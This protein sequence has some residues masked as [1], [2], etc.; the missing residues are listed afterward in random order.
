MNGGNGDPD[1]DGSTNLDEQNSGT[2]P[3][4]NQDFPV[5]LISVS[6][7]G[8]GSTI[9]PASNGG[10]PG[11]LSLSNSW[12]D[13]QSE[14]N[15]SQEL[16]PSFL[17]SRLS[18]QMAFPDTPPEEEGAATISNLVNG[19][20]SADGRFSV[21][22]NNGIT[23]A[24]GSLSQAKVW[25]KSPP[26]T[27]PREF[28]LL[29]MTRELSIPL[30]PS[31]GI[32]GQE[33]ASY[34]SIDVETFTIPAN[35]ELSNSVELL[36]EV[37]SASGSRKRTIV[38]LKEIGIKP[39]DGMVGVVGDMIPSNQVV[40]PELHF[41]SP[42]K[43][44]EIPN[45]YVVFEITGIDEKQIKDGDEAQ[46]VTWVGG[47]AVPDAPLQRRV[48]RDQ[49]AKTELKITTLP[50]HGSEEVANLNVW[51]VWSSVEIQAYEDVHFNVNQ[52]LPGFPPANS[53]YGGTL[54]PS[55]AWRFKFTLQPAEIVSPENDRPDLDGGCKTPVP[56]ETKP[57]FSEPLFADHALRKWDLS[58]QA[59][60]HVSNP[61]SI[62]K[63]KFPDNFI[64]RNQPKELDLAV[65]YPAKAV[66][67]NDDPGGPLWADEDANPYQGTQQAGL[68]HEIGQITSFDAPKIYFEAAMGVP[69]ATLA[70]IVNFREFARVEL[71][72]GKRPTDEQSWYR[73]SDYVEFHH[74]MAAT[75]GTGPEGELQWGNSGSTFG[76]GAFSVD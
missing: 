47:E 3:K 46:V 20:V 65:S 45:D 62:P 52:A 32:A 8:S 4:S 69:D 73:I 34:S 59:Q 42:K 23:N 76:I 72:S 53:S 15:L 12:T 31:G 37:G 71:H 38:S 50:Q 44:D 54:L 75:F 11:T 57:H 18:S 26:S 13:D 70:Q 36:P 2:N 1:G 68:A 19:N 41:V 74:V 7:S 67:G 30:N 39:A 5:Q 24:G 43:T 49:A 40:N 22:T 9:T 16:V 35:E 29:K 33:T 6:R 14:E 10:I 28:R 21:Y 64:Y 55:K 58:R 48:K 27:N 66:E 17:A 51:V 60:I 56:G 61:Q 63:N 25:L